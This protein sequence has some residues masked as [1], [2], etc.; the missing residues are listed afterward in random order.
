MMKKGE[1]YKCEKCG[2]TM[3]IDSDYTC[4]VCNLICCGAQLKK[5]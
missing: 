4:A 1:K 5:L 2:P 3:T